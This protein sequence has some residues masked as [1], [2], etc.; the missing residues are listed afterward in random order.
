MTHRENVL[1]SSHLRLL[2]SPSFPCWVD[3][4]PYSRVRSSK[5]RIG[6]FE[7][8]LHV[9]WVPSL[10]SRS[11]WRSGGKFGRRAFTDELLDKI[12]MARNLATA[13]VTLIAMEF[14]DTRIDW[15]SMFAT[16][17]R[18][19]MWLAY[20]STWRNS[21]RHEIEEFLTH[22]ENLLRIALPNPDDAKV[23]QTLAD[24]LGK[25]LRHSEPRS[26]KQSLTSKISVQAKEK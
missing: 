13:G 6:Q 25:P 4:Q 26:T 22:K 3:L 12:G 20:G 19:D 5:N 11:F 14:R 15:A 23:I 16:S 10:S 8:A 21:H 17:N 18:L 9:S 1:K 2:C 24:R 7:L